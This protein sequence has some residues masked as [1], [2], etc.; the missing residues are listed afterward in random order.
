M[1]E[2]RIE[3]FAERVGGIQALGGASLS[4]ERIVSEMAEIAFCDKPAR[5]SSV[6][7][8]AL[9]YLY[10]AF[11]GRPIEPE[12]SEPEGAGALAEVAK[13]LGPE[14]TRALLVLLRQ[15][16]GTDHQATPAGQPQAVPDPDPE[17]ESR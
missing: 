6:R 14:G 11:G 17:T 4:L 5:N 10:R 16:E 13:A 1:G 12:E 8:K 15:G 2:S 9:C 3:T 7:F